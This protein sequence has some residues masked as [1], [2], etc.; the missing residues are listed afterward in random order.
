LLNA[1]FAMAKAE[2]KRKKQEEAC[3]I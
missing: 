3:E 2:K 1:A